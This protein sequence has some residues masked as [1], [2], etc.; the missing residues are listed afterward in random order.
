MEEE[1]NRWYK[2]LW[3]TKGSRFI[4]ANRLELHEKWSTVTLSVVSVYII[5][6]NL[7]VLLENRPEI[8]SN[9]NI[10]FSTIC[11]S[12]LL[13]VLSLI[14]NSRDYKTRANKYHE[15]GRRIDKLYNEVCLWKNNKASPTNDDLLKLNSEYLHLLDCYEN[16]RHLDY[17]MF[18]SNNL[19][20]YKKKINC[21]LLYWLY[22][23]LRY[24]FTTAW[25][26]WFVL[27]IPL[28]TYLIL[29]KSSALQ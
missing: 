24:Q 19:S 23:K 14:K 3:E 28:L 8:L 27:L 6:L 21:K 13:L 11:L 26:Y 16:H 18:I 15:C 10:T 5:S 29:T 20:D 25:I 22:V 1:I 2:K 7:S 4:A 17:M 12:I 9:E